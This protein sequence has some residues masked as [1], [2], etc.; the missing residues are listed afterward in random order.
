MDAELINQIARNVLTVRQVLDILADQPPDAELHILFASDPLDPSQ[1]YCV[2]PLLD[3]RVVQART[4][5]S[6]NGGRRVLHLE[7]LT[8]GLEEC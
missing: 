4:D 2:E 6:Y 3:V 5:V 1:G 7:G 8:Y